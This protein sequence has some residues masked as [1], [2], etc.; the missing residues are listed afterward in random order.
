MLVSSP[1]QGTQLRLHQ[2]SFKAS[3]SNDH[4]HHRKEREATAAMRRWDGL[5]VGTRSRA[6]AQAAAGSRAQSAACGHAGGRRKKDERLNGVGGG[7]GRCFHPSPLS[8]KWNRGAES[9]RRVFFLL[10]GNTKK[11]EPAIRGMG[12]VVGASPAPNLV[13]GAG[14]CLASCLLSAQ[15]LLPPVLLTSLCWFPLF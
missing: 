2:H 1:H 6:G 4:R 5:G 8:A 13:L 9:G 7:Y 12:G 10:R 15:P 14:S 11:G 3:E